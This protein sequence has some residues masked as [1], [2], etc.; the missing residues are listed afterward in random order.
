ML[1]V[2][3]ELARPLSMTTEHAPRV[4]PWAQSSFDPFYAN[5][6]QQSAFT[7]SHHSRCADG[8]DYAMPLVHPVDIPSTAPCA[9]YSPEARQHLLVCITE[10]YN[11]REMLRGLTPVSERLQR[12]R[13]LIAKI[14]FAHA[15]STHLDGTSRIEAGM[16]GKRQACLLYTS[17]SPR[18][19]LLSRMPSSA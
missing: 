6:S 2:H 5:E 4:G 18:D 14:P 7:E 19:G 8:A 16:G 12:F 1:W 3:R 11:R 9:E 13:S 10:T 17:P 15:Q